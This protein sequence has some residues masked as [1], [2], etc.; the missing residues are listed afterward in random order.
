MQSLRD[1]LNN[2]Q[3]YEGILDP[4]QNQVMIRMTDDMIRQRIREY[5]A[6]DVIKYNLGRIWLVSNP[7]FEI[8][9]I[10]KDD[11]GWYVETKSRVQAFIISNDNTK[12]VYDYCLSYRQKID[13]QKGFLIKDMGIYFR[14]RKHIG[15]LVIDCAPKFEFTEG[16]P[17]EL[18]ILNLMNCCE[19][20][21][22][23]D[24]RNNIN[25]IAISD[26]DDLKISGN[27][28]KNV[29]IYPDSKVGNITA[30]SQTK[31][32]RPETEEE[33]L[34]LRKKLCS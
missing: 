30:P 27:G 6:W 15:G 11:K 7:Y 21:K 17:E 34:D 13:K 28:C 32:L 29:I 9:E 19:K 20:S 26:T 33:Y 4:D 16:L 1:Y 22:K 25:V 12:S 8:T 10:D 31:I 23:L 24:I 14:W 2:T 18:D 5:C 3:Q